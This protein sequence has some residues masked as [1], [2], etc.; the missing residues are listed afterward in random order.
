MGEEG[1]RRVPEAGEGDRMKQRSFDTCPAFPHVNTYGDFMNHDMFLLGSDDLYTFEEMHQKATGSKISTD[2]HIA[3]LQLLYVKTSWEALKYVG[4]KY[5]DWPI[6]DV[7]RKGIWKHGMITGEDEKKQIADRCDAIKK[8]M[9]IGF[10]RI[11]KL[12]GPDA[13]TPTP[14]ED[15]ETKPKRIA[16]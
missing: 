7:V 10:N 11:K 9:A 8:G 14:L 2:P 12:M 15:D 13:P 16:S 4:R 5:H 6:G 3:K 1:T